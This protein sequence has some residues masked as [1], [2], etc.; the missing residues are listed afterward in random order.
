[1]K[2]A[3]SSNAPDAKLHESLAPQRAGQQS[4]SMTDDDVIRAIYSGEDGRANQFYKEW[5][6]IYDQMIRCLESRTKSSIWTPGD[7]DEA[8]DIFL[9]KINNAFIEAFKYKTREIKKPKAYAFSALIFAINT[10]W[11]KIN[12]R[13][14]VISGDQP[15]SEDGSS[16][17][18]L[19]SSNDQQIA[20]SALSD[21]ISE[22]LIPEIDRSFVLS[23]FR[24]M[25]DE[26]E[27]EKKVR[28]ES[29]LSMLDSEK[30]RMV[31]I[32]RT[33]YDIPS[34]MVAECLGIDRANTVD[35]IKLR[36]LNKLRLNAAGL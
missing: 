6:K 10:V 17:F 31:V 11:R 34:V 14:S 5:L 27:N 1:M 20:E 25:E 32:L 2:K 9:T 21:L 30:E 15:M 13:G 4:A 7:K 26:A 23:T 19:L 16:L 29:Y 3:N 8:W 28:A 35:V 36:A 18:D 24:Q 22:D 12:V 33:M